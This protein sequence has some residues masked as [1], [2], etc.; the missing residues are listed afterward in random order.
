MNL[1]I[2]FIVELLIIEFLAAVAFL[3]IYLRVGGIRI[4]RD[5]P[6]K[7]YERHVLT[8]GGLVVILL[9]FIFY[10][11]LWLFSCLD[12]SLFF[13]IAGATLI[14]MIL[15]LIDEF[16]DIKIWKKVPLML[17]PPLPILLISFLSPPWTNT[18]VLWINFG[19]FYWVLVVPVFYMGFS[20]GSNIIAGYDGLEGGIYLIIL[21]LYLII[22]VLLNNSVTF[23]LSSVIFVSL[24]A[25]EL[26]NLPPS[27]LLLGNVGSF[28]IGGLL[29]II[30]LIG[31][32]EII[33]PIVFLPHLIEFLFKIKYRGHTSVFG[34][35]DENGII[36]NKNGIK[37]VLHWIIS[38]GN[39]TEK[40][41]TVVMISIEALLCTIAFFVW[42]VYYFLL[43]SIFK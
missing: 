16:K 27:K 34:I 13:A 30:P 7:P 10:S 17:I 19:I 42:Y 24:L 21:L 20:N 36:R 26:Y 23:L 31:H 4:W 8:G 38:W 15:G 41:I 5:D 9:I 29:G 6:N 33:L 39:M 32:F 35:V 3:Y 43:A 40:R 22:S 2:T 18:Y 14:G 28:P 11:L 12:T 1:N 25:F 37:S